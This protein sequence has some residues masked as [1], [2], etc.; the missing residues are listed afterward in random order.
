[1]GEPARV[2]I[3]LDL[4]ASP[5]AGHIASDREAGRPF[6]GWLELSSQIEARRRDALATERPPAA[7]GEGGSRSDPESGDEY[8]LLTTGVRQS[9]Q[10]WWSVLAA[11]VCVGW[12]AA[13][14]IALAATHHN[15]LVAWWA[16]GL[17]AMLVLVIFLWAD[18][19]QDTDPDDRGE[20]PPESAPEPSPEHGSSGIDWYR[21]ERELNG[22]S[23]ER[24][25]CSAP[26]CG[27]ALPARTGNQRV[28]ALPTSDNRAATAGAHDQHLAEAT[29]IGRR[30]DN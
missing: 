3:D 30:H 19:H 6:H 21:R 23:A 13:A 8:R 17:V 26:G 22:A 2:L 1:M 14:V 18:Q 7:A 24:G 4:D 25:G 27:N 28:R 15:A 11:W 29:R 9:T 10:P 5:I 16:F 20:R 12:S